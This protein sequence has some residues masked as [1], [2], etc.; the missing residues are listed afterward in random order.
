MESAQKEL[1]FEL[2]SL[3]PSKGWNAQSESHPSFSSLFLAQVMQSPAYV[4]RAQQY[5]LLPKRIAQALSPFS[6]FWLTAVGGTV[7]I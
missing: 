3:I 1:H 7:V 6:P 2:C 5:F 4:M